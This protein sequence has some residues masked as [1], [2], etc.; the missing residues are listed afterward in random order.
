MC[1]V[2]NRIKRG[3]FRYTVLSVQHCPCELIFTVYVAKVANPP[4]L[5]AYHYM[6]PKGMLW[7]I[8]LDHLEVAEFK[9]QSSSYRVQFQ[10]KREE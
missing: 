9:R 7:D 5:W 10:F 3:L 1:P 2:C 6:S 8:R 4:Y